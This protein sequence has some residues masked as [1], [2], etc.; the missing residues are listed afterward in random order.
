MRRLWTVLLLLYVCVIYGN[1]MTPASI[2]SQ[3]S[4]AVLS[5]VKEA[6]ERIGLDALWVTEHIIRKTAHF[7]EYAGLGFLLVQSTGL[8]QSR[9]GRRVRLVLEGML[10]IPFLDETIQLF[11][12]GRSAQIS[13]VWLDISGVAAGILVTLFACAV[14]QKR[15]RGENKDEL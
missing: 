3:E 13:D 9:E 2:S 5:L 10:L 15:G 7:L 11:T 14:L 8:W 12:P 6:L 4:G 1:S